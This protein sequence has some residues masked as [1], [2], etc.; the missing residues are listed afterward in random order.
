[1]DKKEFDALQSKLAAEFGEVEPVET[2]LGL[3]F[4]RGVDRPEYKRFLRLA[5]DDKTKADALDVLARI[6]TVY[7]ASEVLDSWL[8]K[9]PAISA[10][11]AD[12][13]LD[14]SGIREVPGSKK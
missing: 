7:P 1:M 8:D 5:S 10:P 6:G 13:I 2:I 11:L 14:M 12:K 4:V 9:K 3:A